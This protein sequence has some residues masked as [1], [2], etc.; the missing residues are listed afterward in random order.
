LIDKFLCTHWWIQEF[1]E[2]GAQAYNGS[3]RALPPVRFRDGAKVRGLHS[4][5]HPPEA[6]RIFIII[7]G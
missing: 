5:L 4:H 1:G 2:C 7:D 3:L 6:E